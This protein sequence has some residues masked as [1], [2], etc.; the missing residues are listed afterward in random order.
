MRQQKSNNIAEAIPHNLLNQC[1]D[2]HRF[3]EV[4]VRF[5]VILPIEN[6]IKFEEE[7]PMNSLFLNDK[8]VLIQ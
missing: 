3:E 6:F 1:D 4:P 7:L 8:A 2:F 5:R